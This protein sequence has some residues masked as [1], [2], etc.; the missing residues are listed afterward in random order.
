MEKFLEQ[1]AAH[2]VPGAGRPHGNVIHLGERDCSMQRRHQKVIE[3]APAPGHHG[4][5]SAS[6]WASAWSRPASADR[7]SQRRHARVPVR[8]QR[9]LL[10]R[11]EH[12]HPGRAPGDGADHRHRPRAR[13]SCASP[14]ARQLPCTQDDVQ[15]RGHAI[16]CRINAEDPKTFTPSPGPIKL[17][18]APGGPGIRVDSHIYTGYN[19]PPHYDSLIAK[20]ISYG[21]TREDGDRA[22]A[23]CAGRDRRRRHQDEHRRCTRKSSTHA[24]FRAG[25]TD[26]HYLERRLGLK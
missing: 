21:D 19:V 10:H 13:R 2:R 25:G 23:Q 14:P 17:W 24:A 22:H 1:P 6:R 26:I 20:I 7:L 16:E 4:Q 5:R 9:V 3:E 11:D 15:L 12:A 18:H 8:G